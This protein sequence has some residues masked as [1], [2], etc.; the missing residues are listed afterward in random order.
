MIAYY[1]PQFHET[2]ENNDWWG[3]GFTEWTNT[4]SA[5]PLFPGHYQPRI[6]YRENYYDL[7]DVNTL[8]EQAKLAIKYGIDAFCIYHY[9]F[10]GKK[11]LYEPVEIFRDTP[12][13]RITYCLSWANEPWTRAWNGKKRQV[14]IDQEYGSEKDWTEHFEYLS[15]FFHDKRYLT[16]NDKPMMII[17]RP[18]HIGKRYSEM[19]DLW[20]KLAKEHGFDGLYMVQTLNGF[21]KKLLPGFDAAIEYEPMY[22]I[23]HSLPFN[24]KMLR[25]FKALSNR[26]FSKFG[27]QWTYLLDTIG[28]D[29]VWKAIIKRQAESTYGKTTYPGAFVDWDNTSRRGGKATIFLGAT[30]EKFLY[31]FKNT[32]IAARKHYQSDLV[33]INAWNEWAEGTYLEPDERYQ[34]SYLEALKKARQEFEESQYNE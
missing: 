10:K 23:K 15:G 5:K 22:T 21:E 8:S 33:F 3:K 31:Y 9:W 25:Y 16:V 32:L 2:P 4:K 13:V 11:L 18:A 29:E 1:L 7:K 24:I 20:D 26:A 14:L 17:H 12:S 28:Y 27:I 30:P 19:I 34:V 6:P